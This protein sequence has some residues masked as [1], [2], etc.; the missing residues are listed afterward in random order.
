[1]SPEDQAAVDAAGASAASFVSTL[2][3]VIFYPLIALLAGVAFVIFLWGCAEYI[4][5][6]NNPAAREKGVKHI[7]YGIIGL[8]VMMSAWAILE[9][10]AATFGVEGSL[11]DVPG[12]GATGPGSGG[13][14]ATPPG[15]GGPGATPPG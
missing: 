2:N 4:M 14:G 5:N 3:E 7:T 15:S 8:V 13:P 10:A 6:A 1:M 9:I 12:S 11:E